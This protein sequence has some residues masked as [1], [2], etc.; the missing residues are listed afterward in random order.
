MW[1]LHSTPLF[2][3]RVPLSRPHYRDWCELQTNVSV[4]FFGFPTSP[5]L[6][7]SSTRWK[8]P[9]QPLLLEDVSTMHAM[10]TTGVFP[11]PCDKT[12]WNNEVPCFPA[13]HGAK[14]N[15]SCEQQ[16][17]SMRKHLKKLNISVRKL[18]HAWRLAGSGALDAAG[19]DNDVRQLPC[20]FPSSAVSA[21]PWISA[22]SIAVSLSL[23]FRFSCSM[24]ALVFRLLLCH[25]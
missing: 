18:S 1:W 25:G 8:L 14:D 5:C 3:S 17:N 23:L 10:L 22:H 6:S 19:V 24:P 15:L 13:K 4:V 9:M 2:T 7:L 11:D 20:L 21:Y 16:A 12:A